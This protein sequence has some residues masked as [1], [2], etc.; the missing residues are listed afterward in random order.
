MMPRIRHNVLNMYCGAQVA[1]V[2]DNPT[3][4]PEAAS[5]VDDI[6]WVPVT[7][8]RQQKGEQVAN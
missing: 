4:V 6:R 5:D 3:A 8:L 2:A 1:A 7:S